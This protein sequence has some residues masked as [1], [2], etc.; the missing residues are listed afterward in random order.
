MKRGMREDLGI[1]RKK[2][3]CETRRHTGE[4]FFLQER[5]EKGFPCENIY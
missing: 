5:T 3:Y 2:F 1:K 4:N